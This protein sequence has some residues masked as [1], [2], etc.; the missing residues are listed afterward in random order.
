MREKEL[1]YSIVELDEPID[2]DFDLESWLA[3]LLVDYWLSREE[4][5]DAS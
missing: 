3:G 1:T 5:S 2:P 4:G